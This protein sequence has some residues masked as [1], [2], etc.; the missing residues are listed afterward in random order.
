MTAND[1]RR[2]FLTRRS[3]LFGFCYF[4]SAS[5][6]AITEPLQQVNPLILFGILVIA[7]VAIVWLVVALWMSKRQVARGQEVLNQQTQETLR[8]Q[9]QIDRFIGGVVQL[10]SS[11]NIVYTNRMAAY[12]LRQKP[13]KCMV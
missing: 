10:D 8:V 3:F 12:F 13:S 7:S 5:A 4:I 11:G 6:W 2:T 1:H 9:E